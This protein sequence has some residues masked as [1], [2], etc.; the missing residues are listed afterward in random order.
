M[1][2]IRL[3]DATSSPTEV[4]TTAGNNVSS[5]FRV[6]GK[7]LSN[8][9][10]ETPLPRTAKTFQANT[11]RKRAPLAVNF[12]HVIFCTQRHFVFWG[13]QRSSLAI[14]T[15]ARRGEPGT[16]LDPYHIPYMTRG[17]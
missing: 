10:R 4:T 8:A 3:V 14:V 2:G 12:T 5:N 1:L 16:R 6:L 13:I 7:R 15:R 17:I 9:S 11:G